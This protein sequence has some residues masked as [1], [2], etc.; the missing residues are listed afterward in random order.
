MKSLSRDD[1]DDGRVTSPRARAMTTPTPTPTTRAMSL[2]SSSTARGADARAGARRA[3]A[4]RTGRRVARRAVRDAS[5]SSADDRVEASES[6]KTSRD[7]SRAEVVRAA[8]ASGAVAAA[9]SR[10]GGGG[11][12]RAR[13]LD[14]GASVEEDRRAVYDGKTWRVRHGASALEVREDGTMRLSRTGDGPS[15][16]PRTLAATLGGG[17]T[18]RRGDARVVDARADE[19]S[20]SLM[21]SW[22][23]GTELRVMRTSDAMGEE[24][25]WCRDVAD[26][27]LVEVAAPTGS[28]GVAELTVRL[29]EGGEKASHWYGGSH[30]LKQLWP[31]ERAKIETGPFYPF[32]HGPNGVGNVL[33]THWVSSDGALIFADPNSD[34]LHVGLNAPKS[35][36]SSQA[37][38]YF[39]VGIQNA[40]RPSLPLEEALSSER[41][42][43]LLRLQSR[44]NYADGNMLHPWQNID[45]HDARSRLR[46]RVAVSVQ[47][48]AKSATRVALDQLPKPDVAPNKSLMFSPIWTTWATSHADVTQESTLAVARDILKANKESGLPNGSIIEI[49]DRWQARYGELVF[50]PVKFPD[51]KAMVKELHDMGFLVTAWVM[52]F[53]Q[54]SS[55][56]C[57]EAKRLGYLVEGSQPPTEVG[58]VLTGGFGQILGTTVKVFVDRFDWPPGH[59][60]GGGG[61]GNL[62]PGQFRW[63][64]TQPV[65]GIDFTNEAACEWFVRRLEK[66]QDEVGLD[67]FK[68]DAGEPCFLPYGART[69]KPLNHPQEY[70]QAYV[71]NVCSKFPLSEVRVGM[72]TNSYTGLV[73]MGDKDTVWGVDN[74]LQSL[75]PSL[76]TSAVIGYPFTLPDIIGGNAY[77][78]Q[79]PDTE[80]MIRW[81]QVS[82]FMPAVQWSIPPWE[83]SEQAY[84]ASVELMRMREELLLPKLEA[85]SEAAK[86]TLEPICRPMWWLDPKDAST[87]AID[88]QFAVGDDIIIAPV[89]EK[90][91]TSRSVYLPR[92][93]W[94]RHGDAAVLAG[95][96]RFI[97]DAPLS[98]LPV[99]LRVE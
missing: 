59:W 35:I 5:S 82:A 66:L 47:E 3:V 22:S 98:Q 20:G 55:A 49:D 58:E 13:D 65:R 36:P 39:G 33:G 69:H 89:V 67:G 51:P 68:F 94:R 43:G 88:D 99:F 96:R 74:G 53:L 83:V 2:S 44:A 24:D 8:V 76:L 86:T 15:T 31:L 11:A 1:D 60:E 79:T 45:T 85:L 46:L 42:D 56:A 10:V 4:G 61:G 32:D 87:F 25:A 77:W 41:G 34:L 57:E 26:G 81:A 19:A 52:P 16:R 75:I 12:P 21:V 14:G 27:L 72:G 78:N 6:E 62:E 54:E 93:A 28:T 73:R 92:G 9:A 91:A 95:G 37:P 29:R 84:A 63:W 23:D 30:L 50:D 80:L 17:G 48:D 97:V 90:G 64:G 7:V 40:S 71:E 38:R 18:G 70:S